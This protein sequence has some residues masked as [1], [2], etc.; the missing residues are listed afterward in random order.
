MKILILFISIFLVVP[1]SNHSVYSSYNNHFIKSVQLNSYNSTL[2]DHDTRIDL[3]D[4]FNVK[5]MET[6]DVVNSMEDPLDTL[7]L[8]FN[9]SFSNRNFLES[10]NLIFDEVRTNFLFQYNSLIY[11]HI[12]LLYLF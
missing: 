8:W 11:L 6:L 3:S 12:F 10:A 2:F 4:P 1:I 5:V 9:E 7:E